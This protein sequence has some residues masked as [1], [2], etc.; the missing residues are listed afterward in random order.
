MADDCSGFVV[1]A[2]DPT[3]EGSLTLLLARDMTR[4]AITSTITTPL[5]I[6]QLFDLLDAASNA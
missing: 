3:F 6:I 2:V 4:S 5:S 1:V